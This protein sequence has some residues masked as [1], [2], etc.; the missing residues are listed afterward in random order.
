MTHVNPEADTAIEHVTCEG[1]ALVTPT[2]LSEFSR[3]T[4]SGLTH[5]R[6]SGIRG[7]SSCIAAHLVRSENLQFV[8]TQLVAVVAIAADRWCPEMV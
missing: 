5:R 4:R 3:S 1:V 6:S 7:C 8:V 2:V